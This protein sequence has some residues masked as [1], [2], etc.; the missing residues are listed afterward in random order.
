M[1]GLRFVIWPVCPPYG[2]SNL[3][4]AAGC[5]RSSSQICE[6][7]SVAWSSP[8]SPGFGDLRRPPLPIDTISGAFTPP[9]NQN[10]R[11]TLTRV[12]GL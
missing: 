8:M 3:T 7:R 6:A 10:H 2:S 5:L 4:S 9:R 11:R 1:A 12:F